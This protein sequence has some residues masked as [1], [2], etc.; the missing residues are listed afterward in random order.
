MF[1]AGAPALFVFLWSTGWISARYAADDADALTFLSW[2]YAFA[3]IALLAFVQISRAA[4]PTTRAAGVHAMISGVLLHGIYLGGVWWAL[5]HGV[6]TGISGVIAALQPIL[7]AF[8]A[9]LLIAERISP[10]RWLGVVLGF[11]GIVVVL[12]PKVMAM[13]AGTLATTLEPLAVNVVGMLSVTLGTFYQKRF[14]ATG[15]L[16]TITFLQY[17]GAFAFTLPMALYFEKGVM[18]VTPTLVLTMVW[19]VFALSIGAI[20]LSLV[21]I[22]RGAVS[23]FAALIYLVPPTVAVE[24]WLLFGETLTP[25]QVAGMALTVAGVALATRK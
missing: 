14:V 23:R 10:L 20:A 15:D 24:A 22:R 12:S 1:D 2:R 11:A 21:M 3:G 4:W 9:P 16:R 8:L 13:E 6:P 19:S 7:T 18:H 25:V 17:V 5:R